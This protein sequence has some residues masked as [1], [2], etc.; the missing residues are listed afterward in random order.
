MKAALT[1]SVCISVS[2]TLVARSTFS[3]NIVERYGKLPLAFEA[4][5]GQ[6]DPQVKFLSRGAGY[7]LFLTSNEAV[8]ALREASRQEPA[9][10]GAKAPASPAET[11]R[12][13]KSAVLR[14]KL[15]GSNAKT[16]VA[17]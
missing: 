16:E 7:R 9:L 15:V 1:L 11:S 17:G 2:L 6:S 4:N 13:S 3:S 12:P 14:M 8:L 10:P 5:Q